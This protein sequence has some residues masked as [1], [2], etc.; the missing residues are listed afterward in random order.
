MSVFRL[1]LQ[2]IGSLLGLLAILMVALAP[3]ISQTLAAT[4]HGHAMMDGHCSMP[5][6]PHEAPGS[7]SHTGSTM[8]DGQACGYCG[9]LAHIP[10]IPGVPATFAAIVRASLHPVATRFE[11]VRFVGPLT[12][13]QPRAPPVLS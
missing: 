11:S 12:P 6:M 2:K 1:G 9:L 10:V 3:T 5:S 8:S 4:R 13:A 7:Q